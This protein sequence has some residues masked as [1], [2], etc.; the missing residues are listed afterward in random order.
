MIL[1][2]P[3]ISLNALFSTN[4]AMNLKTRTLLFVGFFTTTLGISQW[5]QTSGPQGGALKEIVAANGNL[6]LS[7][8]EAG[9]YLST[10]NGTSWRTANSGLPCNITIKKL[11]SD[12][13]FVYVVTEDD[14]LFKS[15]DFGASWLPINNGISNFT[16]NSI[17]A[18]GTNLYAANEDGG[19]Y[20]SPNRGTSWEEKSS[21][22]AMVLFN[23][24]TMFNGQLFAAGADLFRTTDNGDTW[25]SVG[26]PG[27]LTGAI[28][29]IAATANTLFITDSNAVFFSNGALTTWTAANV[30]PNAPITSIQTS[31]NRVFLTTS[32]GRIFFS[33]NEGVNWNLIQNN[34]TDRP[35]E[36]ALFTNGRILMTTSEGL[37]SSADSGLNWNESNNGILAT[38]IESLHNN[39]SFIYAGT[40]NQHVFRS[41]DNGQSWT[42]LRNGLNT[43]ESS[44]VS[45]IITYQGNLL[46]ATGDGVYEST[47]DGNSWAKILDPGPGGNVATLATRDRVILAGVNGVGL[48]ISLDD[49]VS[50]S[51]TSGSG[52]GIN[53]D[54]ESIVIQSATILISARN[55]KVFESIDFGLNWGEVSITNGFTLVYKLILHEDKLYAATARGFWVSDNFGGSWNA[56][57]DESIPLFDA[58]I[59]DDL[60]YA[61]SDQGVFVASLDGSPWFELCAG[62][63]KRTVNELS[64]KD[65]LLFGGTLSSSVWNYDLSNSIFPPEEGSS[66]I[67]E[68]VELCSSDTPIDLTSLLPNSIELGGSWSPELN[69]TSNILNPSVDSSGI[70]TYMLPESDCGCSASFQVQVDIDPQT[71]AGDDIVLEACIN[72]EPFNLLER[73]GENAAQGGIWSP[74]LS[75]GSNIFNPTIDAA[76]IYSYTVTFDCGQDTAEATISISGGFEIPSDLIDIKTSSKEG[77]ITV[78]VDYDNQFEFSL[79]GINY[80]Q[81]NVLAVLEGGSYTVFGREINGC[82]FF[83]KE[84]SLLFIPKFFSPNMDSFN[85]YWEISGEINQNFTLT[86]FDRFGKLLKQLD[87]NNSRW[88]GNFN[89]KRLPSSDYWFSIVFE[90]GSSESGHFSLIR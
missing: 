37:F 19:V 21:G 79:D 87:N 48:Y 72:N 39:D 50:W 41:D 81:N 20:Y 49:G 70:Y 38:S 15:E 14:G 11:I 47:D 88:D 34:N 61:G 74:S 52:L 22:I 67:M 2:N 46:I 32:D 78:M 25:S 53:S 16:F 68:T 56:F 6:I 12:D 71:S 28:K 62:I 58:E 66:N 51:L 55:G 44:H 64:L 63:G 73:L 35:A 45:D 86:I 9:L 84:V 60:V 29:S 57:N 82:G 76:G 89:G 5:V 77:L 83:Q 69:S 7:A 85:D 31:G 17:Y 40:K 23:D 80:T 33:V 18:D 4:V 8:G 10:N 13:E 59:V 30:N 27:L 42:R 75:S 43:I 3:F 1:T 65:D 26:L 54:Y 90:N 24:F 36:D